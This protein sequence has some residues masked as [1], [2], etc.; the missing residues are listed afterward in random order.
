MGGAVIISESMLDFV[1]MYDLRLGQRCE[2]EFC[3]L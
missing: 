2:C 3:I 1:S